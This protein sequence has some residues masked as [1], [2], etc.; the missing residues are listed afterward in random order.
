MKI[1]LIQNDAFTGCTARFAGADVTGPT[2]PGTDLS[3]T[4]GLAA[5]MA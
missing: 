1:N 5:A 4:G 3:S 2:M